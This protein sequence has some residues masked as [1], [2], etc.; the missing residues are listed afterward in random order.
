M[1]RMLSRKRFASMFSRIDWSSEQSFQKNQLESKDV[2]GARGDSDDI[3]SG[4]GGDEPSEAARLRDG[5]PPTP[6]ADH[7]EKRRTTVGAFPAFY[8]LFARDD[9]SEP[10]HLVTAAPKPTRSRYDP[11]SLR[12]VGDIDGIADELEEE[13]EDSPSHAATR[14]K[15]PV[16]RPL[17]AVL[18]VV[19]II[20]GTS[21]GIG[22]VTG[23]GHLRA[24]RSAAQ[25]QGEGQRLLE[26]AESIVAACRDPTN[27]EC[28]ALCGANMCCM[29]GID[30]GD[31]CDDGISRECAVYAGCRTLLDL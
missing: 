1:D 3:S 29:S 13:Q 31:P 8:H 15:K 18:L 24:H 7:D 16:G 2:D 6:V 25:R 19:G 30:H 10:P 26:L 12:L 23:S 5:A 21:V 20:V 22:A 27:D 9:G 11:T 17:L 14:A 28:P 4:P